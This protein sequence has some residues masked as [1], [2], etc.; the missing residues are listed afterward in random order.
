MNNRF[1]DS[2]QRV[3]NELVKFRKKCTC[4]HTMDVP[5]SWKGEYRICNHCG[6]RLYKDPDKQKAHNEKVN[7]EEFIF[8]FTQYMKK[9]DL[10]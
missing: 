1:I 2:I 7:K 5:N 10:I 8:K 3:D 4:G 9:L 6:H